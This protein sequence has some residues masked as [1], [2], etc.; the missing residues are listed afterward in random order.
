MTEETSSRVGPD[1]TQGIPLAEIAEG[2]MVAGDVGGET[3]LLVHQAGELFAVG[4]TCTHSGAP[5]ADGLL[6]GD[7]IP[8]PVASCLCQP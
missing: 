8:M 7:T 4:A 2:S 6:V 3:V 5:L 1:L